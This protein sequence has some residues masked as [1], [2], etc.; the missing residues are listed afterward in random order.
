MITQTVSSYVGEI[1]GW[2]VCSRF[3]CP[4]VLKESGGRTAKAGESVNSGGR[5]VVVGVR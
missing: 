1:R 4:V 2:V 5:K 3:S